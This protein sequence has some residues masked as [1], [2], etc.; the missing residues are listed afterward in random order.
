MGNI[1]KTLIVLITI[2]VFTFSYTVKYDSILKDFVETANSTELQVNQYVKLSSNFIETMGV[3][4]NQFFKHEHIY[5]HDILKYIEYDSKG[6]KYTLDAIEG[7]KDRSNFGN[8]TGL[9]KMSLGVTDRKEMLLALNYNYY[10][11][12]FYNN[13]PGIA[14]IYYTSKN[15]FMNLYPWVHSKDFT[16]T[17]EVMKKEFYVRGLPEAN[18]LRERFWSPV[19]LDLAGKGLMVTVSAPVYEHNEF[20]GVISLDFTTN[21]L[22]SLLN[23]KYDAFLANGEDQILAATFK[24]ALLD[25]QIFSLQEFLEG[26]SPDEILNIKKA[27]D[28]VLKFI[29]GRYVFSASFK[30][31][32]WR[33]HYVLPQ[34][35]VILYSLLN[36][37]P[38][39]AIGVLLVLST[40]ETEARKKTELKLKSTV[41]ELKAYQ[42]ML[43]KAA[44]MDFLTNTLNRRGMTDRSS[45]EVARHC[46]NQKPLSFILADIDY[47]KRINDDYGHAT[48]DKVLIEIASIMKKNVRCSDL[49]CRWGG[50]EFLILLPETKYEDALIVA[51]KLRAE[52]ENLSISW[53]NSAEIKTTITIGVNEYDP[54]IGTEHC[55]SGADKAL[56]AGKER[57][58]NK[59]VGYR[60]IKDEIDKDLCKL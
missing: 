41:E 7:R 48:G 46:R 28:K 37:L 4:G 51:E 57:G 32:P 53:E 20:K 9:G 43:E 49:V 3:F 27:E 18:P 5:D 6:D 2:G 60:D 22:N 11:S 29:D 30:N 8:V 56:Y 26:Y 44:T 50:E 35:I 47:F 19:Y 25:K 13:L 39:L 34:N 16:F 33:L 24:S 31:A 36:C 17:D 12:N 10:F 52:V 54:D 59:V 58:R 40:N 15:R 42:G 45:E 23:P 55:I 14:W 1:R 38:V 21:Q